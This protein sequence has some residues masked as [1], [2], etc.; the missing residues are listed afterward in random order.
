M[1]WAFGHLIQL[2]NPDDY[3]PK[4]KNWE[5]PSLPIIPSEFKKTITQDEGAIRQFNAIK[6]LLI[7]KSTTEII[8]ATDAGREGELI[9]RYI[10]E[11]AGCDKPIKRLWI[12]SQT[13]AAI[14]EGF[15]NLVDGKTMSLCM[16]LQ[17]VVLKP[18]G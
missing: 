6:S 8:C 16:I 10:Y 5:L 18:T 17:G 2:I 11:E 7:N 3:D 12:S 15:E 14:K 13:D 9:F 4:Y 1:T